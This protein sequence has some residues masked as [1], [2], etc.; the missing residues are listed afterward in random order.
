MFYNS[1]LLLK[2]LCKY[3]L[4]EDAARWE[5]KSYGIL[6]GISDRMYNTDS[7]YANVWQWNTYFIATLKCKFKISEHFRN[8]ASAK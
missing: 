6:P 3:P 7:L 4:W 1:A 8:P 2:Y 5:C